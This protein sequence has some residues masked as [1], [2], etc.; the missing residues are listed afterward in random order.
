[1]TNLSKCDTCDELY[2]KV[3]VAIRNATIL[4]EESDT[5]IAENNALIANLH[6][7][8]KDLREEVHNLAG[9]ITTLTSNYDAIIHPSMKTYN[10]T[11]IWGK[12]DELTHKMTALITEKKELNS[13]VNDLIIVIE[14]LG[15]SDENGTTLNGSSH[16]DSG[17]QQDDSL[18]DNI[19]KLI[20]DLNDL[21]EKI[22]QYDTQLRESHAEFAANITLLTLDKN[23][24]S[25]TIDRLTENITNLSSETFA[26]REW[27]KSNG[28][29]T[30]LSRCET[31]NGLRGEV[32]NLARN[33]TALTLNYSNLHVNT[34]TCN[35]TVI[36]SIVDELSKNFTA[37][38]F[39]NIDLRTK[40]AELTERID[41]GN[42]TGLNGHSQ[43]ASG[44]TQDVKVLHDNITEL[45]TDMN[46]M[47]GEMNRIAGLPMK[48]MNLSDSMTLLMLDNHHLNTKVDELTKNTTLNARHNEQTFII[49]DEKVNQ[50]IDNMTEHKSV[51]D[52]I[53]ESVTNLTTENIK[54]NLN[55]D[56]IIHNV[57]VLTSDKDRLV[58]NISDLMLNKHKLDE[59]VEQLVHNTTAMKAAELELETNISI[60][61]HHKDEHVEHIEQM[62]TNLTALRSEKDKLADRVVVLT[63]DYDKTTG[64]I[65]QII[66]NITV[67]TSD[68]NELAENISGLALEKDDIKRGINQIIVNLT[69]L[70]SEK[71]EIN[72]YI[73]VI[74][75]NISALILDKNELANNIIDL[76]SNKEQING[77]IEKI[78]VN[79]TTLTSE[80]DK[81]VENV[82]ALTSD[83]EKLTSNVIDLTAQKEEM[84]RNIEKIIVNVTELTLDKDELANSIMNLQSEKDEIS[85][86]ID[87]IAVNVTSLASDKDKFF[88]NI[89]GLTLKTNE[90][91]E[92]LDQL[93]ENV[94]SDKAEV[95]EKIQDLISHNSE[96]VE[97]VKEI[98]RNVSALTS[99]KDQLNEKVIAL[100]S[101][102][103]EIDRE[104]DQVTGNVTTL[105]SYQKQ[106]EEHVVALIL[107]NLKQNEK[108]EQITA[109]VT[110]LTSDTNELNR[111][112]N[113]LTWNVTALI[114]YKKHILSEKFENIKENITALGV[115]TNEQR[116][117]MNSMA[118]DLNFKVGN[119]EHTFHVVSTRVN[120]LAYTTYVR[121][122]RTICPNSTTT[123]Y[124]GITGGSHWEKTGGG[125]EYK[126]LPLQPQWGNFNDRTARYSALMYGV[127]YQVE[128]PDANPFL[129]TNAPSDSNSLNDREVPCVLCAVPRVTTL[130][131][132]AR[133]TCPSGWTQ[134][135][136][137][138]LM[139]D[140]TE[141]HRTSWICVDEAPEA[142]EGRSRIND[143][144]AMIYV[145]EAKCGSLPCSQ[146]INGRELT[147]VVCTR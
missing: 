91:T 51:T 143:N 18:H 11:G 134:E 138:Y 40:V 100:T 94:T 67:L 60:L 95:V 106:L 30:D 9:N 16:H 36:K 112:V 128:A 69:A 66:G 42:V 23:Q 73:K 68:K 122:G 39:N 1:M 55:V 22:C 105:I 130:M 3:E 2:K 80:K 12:V 47:R 88:E 54:M 118:T 137:G 43:P 7:D 72:R 81:L 10:D 113:T 132:P 21:Q 147:C 142:K 53:T 90:I 84:N 121:W 37:F 146:Y 26:A 96:Q 38:K 17:S 119:L 34:N 41:V 83:N 31:C 93:V 76:I 131:I 64:T 124:E 123:L 144:Q 110:D 129:H 126:C 117:Q 109:N 20:T 111:E 14:N 50:I 70:T 135:Y 145:V 116:R 120:N 101:D 33:I 115:T 24:L 27:S 35:I 59:T 19:T 57:T 8:N 61:T 77:D 98:I 114:L 56:K 62:I 65:D 82:T 87:E 15:V 108:L 28:N 99:D 75:E 44:L 133:N 48:L 63:S 125:A 25:E 79:V 49:L 4:R 89:I 86:N 104:V 97:M 71:V 5:L 103:N 52:Q 127:E 32:H 46:D 140:Y 85:I 78:I 107:E 45:I 136:K 29:M 92:K 13:K 139:A 141:G 58:E 102:K 74:N 6:R